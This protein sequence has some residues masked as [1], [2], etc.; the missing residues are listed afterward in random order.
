VATQALTLLNNESVLRQA[1]LFA[2]RLAA[3]APG[4]LARQVDLAY[5][6]ALT[7]SPRP[8]EAQVARALVTDQSLEALTHIL[9]NLN[10]FRYMR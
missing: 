8:E 7:R 4:D 1:E 6:I 3:L 2:E 10:E 9:F 5:R